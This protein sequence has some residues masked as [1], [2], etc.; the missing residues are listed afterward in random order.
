MTAVCQYIAAFNLVAHW[1][2]HAD[3]FLEIFVNAHF[4]LWK[5][6]LII[7]IL[8]KASRIRASSEI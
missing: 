5:L 4:A 3:C 1:E 8:Q 2:V 7:I 6:I